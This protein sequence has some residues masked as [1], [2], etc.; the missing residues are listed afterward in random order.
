MAKVVKAWPV[1][2][3]WTSQSNLAGQL[4]K[5]ASDLPAV[6]AMAAFLL[7]AAPIA[8]DSTITRS[9]GWLLAALAASLFFI[10]VLGPG[11]PWR[12]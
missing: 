7:A 9:I 1:T 11:I 5:G 10:A 6:Q 4:V 8:Q 2:G 3:V 12:L